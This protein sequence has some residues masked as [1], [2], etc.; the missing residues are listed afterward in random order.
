MVAFWLGST[1]ARPRKLVAPLRPPAPLSGA[2]PPLLT[3]VFGAFLYLVSF[4]AKVYMVRAGMYSY[5]A[6]FDVTHSRVAE[7]QVFIVIANF[8]L[9]ALILFAIELHYHPADRIRAGLFWTVLASQ[10][11]WGLISGMKSE[12]LYNFVSVGIVFSLAGRKLRL[13][14]FA[15]AILGLVALYPLINEY[16]F[17]VRGPARQ[18]TTSVSDAVA[19]MRQAGMRSAGREETA[20]DWV[21]AGWASA[22][23]RFDMLENV[24]ML[25]A[26]Q[27]RSFQLEGDERLWMI[28]FYPLV[29]RFIWPSKPVQD[30]GGRLTRLI[31]GSR[32]TGTSPTVLGDLYVL[33]GGIPGLLAGMFLL[34]LAAQWLTNLVKLR[35]SKRNLFIYAGTFF[36]LGNYQQDFFAFSTAAIRAFVILQILAAIIYGP[37]WIPPLLRT[38]RET[39]K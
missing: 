39:S 20:G 35:P 15:I 21:A 34:G 11:F 24:A 6:S 8:G 4:A 28:P 32:D 14:W 12:V 19:A 9:F 1:I 27:D 2:G 29:P 13:R 3:V 10:C 30:F 16:R 33:H 5:I 25:M 37:V 38:R 31:G 7:V 23:G 36:F 17:I 22:V 26:Y 18:A